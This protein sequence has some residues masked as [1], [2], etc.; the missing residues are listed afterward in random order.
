[1]EW[2]NYHHLLYFWVVAR[3]GTITSAAKT[4]SL[5]P[6]TI[7]GQINQLEASMGQKLF[8]RS[9]RNIVLTDV[10]RSVFRYADDIFTLGRELMDFVHGRQ[11]KRM[12][13]HVGI[14]MVVP[15]LVASRLVEPALALP[16]KIHLFCHEGSTEELMADLA[17]HHLDVVLT[18]A[19]LGQDTR[20][21]A[22]NH[23]LGECG[24]SF[25]AAPHLAAQL[26]E[27]FPQSLT[28]ASVLLPM[29][30]SAMRRKLDHW[31]QDND[32]HPQIEAEFDDSALMKV[33][34]QHGRGAFPVPSVVIDEIARQ[35]GVE[36]LGQISGVKESFY[37]VSVQRQLRHPGV[38]AISQAATMDLFKDSKP[39]E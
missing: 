11:L 12:H 28:G 6:S 27:G 29:S 10:G 7:S 38:V 36:H 4:L 20:V 18:D 23:L 21:R 2:L 24:V 39:P 19:P 22:F 34:G 37:A 35:Y 16:E 32:I 3:E 13:L 33:F 5:S 14:S 15:K 8:K 1:M 17:T 26:R 30:S 31:F 25:V 9:G